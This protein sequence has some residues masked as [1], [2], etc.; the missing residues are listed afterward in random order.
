MIV[1]NRNAFRTVMGLTL[2]VPLIWSLMGV[3]CPAGSGGT[4]GTGET[5]G[6]TTGGGG[7]TTPGDSGVTGKYK[8]PNACAQCHANIHSDW[9]GT[10][11]SRALEVLESVGQ[12]TNPDCLK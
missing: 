6:D 5:G 4:G 1:S 3:G 12:G 7:T 9:M 11:H 2:A 8:G 10:L